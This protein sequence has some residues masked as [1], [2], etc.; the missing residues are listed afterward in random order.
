MSTINIFVDESG[1]FGLLG[2]DLRK[3]I[4]DFQDNYYIISIL[5]HDNER[6][7]LDEQFS[8][9]NQS[10]FKFEKAGMKFIHLS[11]ILRH[12]TSLTKLFT[13]DDT[14]KLFLSF[15]NF[16]KY[17]D[18]NIAILVLD[19]RKV[20]NQNE[21]ERYFINELN[22]IFYTNH[23]FF[24]KYNRVK[25]FYDKGQNWVNNII[26]KSTSSCFK[27]VIDKGKIQQKDYRLLQVCDF[28]CTTE[29]VKIK[30]ENGKSSNS[31]SVVFNK[32]QFFKDRILKP[33]K[34]KRIDN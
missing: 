11:A 15:A 33:I 29:L 22:N 7:N 5:F 30:K 18:I 17:S 16:I 8:H 12:E 28:L 23:S 24:S 3:S 34:S 14:R 13:A 6:V 2:D 4:H 19:K 31:E 20:N 25:I 21:F 10:C 32:N 1:D 26:K 27:E 9:L